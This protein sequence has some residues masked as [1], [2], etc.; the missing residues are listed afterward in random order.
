MVP[1][2]SSASNKM[3]RAH[4]DNMEEELRLKDFRSKLK[5]V[6]NISDSCYADFMSNKPFLA[7]ATQNGRSVIDLIR[8]YTCLNI[9][10]LHEYL[11]PYFDNP[12]ATKTFKQYCQETT[13]PE[14][15]KFNETLRNT[16]LSSYFKLEYPNMSTLNSRI[17]SSEERGKLEMTNY[18]QQIIEGTSKVI[19]VEKPEK[20]FERFG[21]LEDIKQ[22]RQTHNVV[23]VCNYDTDFERDLTV[24]AAILPKAGLLSTSKYSLSSPNTFKKLESWILYDIVPKLLAP[25]VI[26]LDDTIESKDHITLPT[27]NSKHSEM[28]EWLKAKNIP[29]DPDMH[30]PEL[31]ELIKRSKRGEPENIYTIDTKLN[32]KGHKVLRQPKG[33][34]CLKY[35]INK[36]RTDM[37]TC[38]SRHD[39]T[40]HLETWQNLEESL[41]QLEEKLYKE[42]LELENII[43][44]LLTLG[45]YSPES[46]HLFDDKFDDV[47]E[48]LKLREI[49]EDPIKR[50]CLIHDN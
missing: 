6:R 1:S 38:N 19:L 30:R 21:Y 17:S 34:R 27:I 25:S 35:D 26:V 48:N 39:V 24:Y 9:E 41:I 18:T 15:S 42:D 5:V 14:N 33:V 47:P 37:R 4:E 11:K 3:H 46:S 20:F 36:F 50:R 13:E 31:Y 10:L 45:K 8:H 49:F 40:T 7:T 32:A 23:Y 2:A 28:I 22:L 44:Q 43:D 29:H 16:I 12:H